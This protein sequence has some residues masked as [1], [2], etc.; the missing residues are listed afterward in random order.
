[1]IRNYLS[2]SVEQGGVSVQPVYYG[3]CGETANPV[4]ATGPSSSALSFNRISL[5]HRHSENG[6]DF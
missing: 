2:L 4:A 5:F 3:G 6:K 1:M